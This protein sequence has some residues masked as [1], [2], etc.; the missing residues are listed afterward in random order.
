MPSRDAH[1]LKEHPFAAESL[2]QALCAA[3]DI[4]M[5]RLRQRAPRHIF[6]RGFRSETET[7]TEMFGNDFWPD[8]EPNRLTLDALM[9]YLADQR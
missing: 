3:K 6:C 1:I 8:G 2:Y 5:H 7:L 9:T 4:A